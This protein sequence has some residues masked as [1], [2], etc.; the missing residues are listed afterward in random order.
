MMGNR[1]I[2]MSETEKGSQF[3]EALVKLLT[4]GDE[5]AIRAMYRETTTMQPQF[6]IFMVA[7]DLPKFRGEE[8]SMQRRLAV[9]PFLSQFVDDHV[10]VNQQVNDRYLFQKNPQLD[11][12]IKKPEIIQAICRILVRQCISYLNNTVTD[13][14]NIIRQ[15]TM[16]YIFENND[17]DLFIN[18][19]FEP[20]DDDNIYYTYSEITNYYKE[21]L[22]SNQR[23]IP[24][25]LS[26]RNLPGSLKDKFT[27]KMKWCKETKKPQK[28]LCGLRYI[29]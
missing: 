4:G 1:F 7:N 17:I 2:Y 10:Q 23:P 3:N 9:I 12:W 18:Q 16:D 21:F 24:N 13:I 5:I 19:C 27:V 8:Y 25:G 6:K 14:P 26:N 15:H 22:R 11:G 29:L 20:T 28:G